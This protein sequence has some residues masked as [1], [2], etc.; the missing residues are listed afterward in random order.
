MSIKP[1]LCVE[2]LIEHSKSKGIVFN[3]ISESDAEKYL[4]KNN[5]YFKLTSY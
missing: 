2:D 4:D 3:I 1:M 5:N